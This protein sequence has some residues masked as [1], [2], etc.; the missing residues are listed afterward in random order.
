MIN[1]L[2]YIAT[3]LLPLISLIQISKEQTWFYTKLS[4]VLQVMF[5][6]LQL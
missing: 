3:L 6:I 4:K 2:L 5:D 1:F